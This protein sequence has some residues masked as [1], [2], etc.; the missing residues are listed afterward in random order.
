MSRWEQ[1]DWTHFLNI[2]EDGCFPGLEAKATARPDN[3]EAYF[4]GFPLALRA[5]HVIVPDWTVAGLVIS[6]ASGAVAVLALSRIAQLHLP[7]SRTA[8][9][10]V[11]LSIM[12]VWCR[13]LGQDAGSAAAVSTGSP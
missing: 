10:A 9:R 6:L 4:P 12:G 5:V 11:R 13:R 2:A 1:W 3:R 8:P 7:G